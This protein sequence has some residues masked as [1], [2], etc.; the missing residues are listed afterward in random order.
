MVA[1]AIFIAFHL[2]YNNFLEQIYHCE[3]LQE[4]LTPVELERSHEYLSVIL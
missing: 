2:L 3:S 4:Y 1:V